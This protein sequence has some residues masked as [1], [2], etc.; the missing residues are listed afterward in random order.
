MEI[1]IDRTHWYDRIW[2][3]LIFFTRLP[4]WRFHQPPKE[5]YASVVEHWPLVGWL[6][7]GVMAAVLWFGNMVM[8]W[9]VTVIVAIVVRLLEGLSHRHLWRTWSY[10]LYIIALGLSQ[11][12]YSMDGCSCCLCC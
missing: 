1:N 10:P 6:T 7:G 11:F 5:C 4:F 8:P 2:A 12:T 3:S 9:A